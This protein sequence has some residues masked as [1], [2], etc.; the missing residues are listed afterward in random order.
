MSKVSLAEQIE[1]LEEAVLMSEHMFDDAR[2]A[3]VAALNTLKIVAK[4]EKEVRDLLSLCI[5]RDE[6]LPGSRIEVRE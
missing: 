6:V 3:L 1:A 4:Y 2:E 5:K